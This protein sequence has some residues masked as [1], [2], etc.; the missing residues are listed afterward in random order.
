MR[1]NKKLQNYA[2]ESMQHLKDD[3]IYNALLQEHRKLKEERQ[4][5][6]PFYSLKQFKI[7]CTT[8]ACIVVSLVVALCVVFIDPQETPNINDNNQ[9]ITDNLQQQEPEIPSV[10]SIPHI[11][12]NLQQQEPEIPSV[13]S[14]PHYSEENKVLEIATSDKFNTALVESGI[15]VSVGNSAI[16]ETKDGPSGDILFYT[17]EINNE[18]EMY[19]CQLEIVTNQYYDSKDIY[20]TSKQIISGKE[21]SINSQYDYIEEDGLY[22]HSVVAETEV[23]GI[24]IIVREFSSITFSEDSGFQE[25]IESTFSFS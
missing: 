11:T 5:K 19:S 23:D 17:I 24:K 13:P 10:P 25:F 15:S 6:K 3:D 18:E 14:I 12:D 1:K 2:N 7:A 9:N 4:S 16:T 8:C 22:I 20:T 21:F